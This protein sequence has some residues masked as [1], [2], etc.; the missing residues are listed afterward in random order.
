M[1]MAYLGFS[2]L[3]PPLVY[4]LAQRALYTDWR[5]RLLNLPILALLG[6]GI[7]LNNTRAVAE[8]LRGQ[9]GAFAR[10][11]KFRLEENRGDW[12]TSEYRL[13][14]GWITL[15]EALL[16]LYALA[17]VVVAFRAGNF[18]AIP[19]LLL[20]FGGFGLTAAIGTWQTRGI[21]QRFRRQQTTWAQMRSAHAQDRVIETG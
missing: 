2:S 17:T 15:G 8:A 18:Y 5:R 7:A 14:V 9:G 20:Y 3:G 21:S 16:S 19:F 11:P 4:A 10:T 12:I 1:A 6:T 13:P